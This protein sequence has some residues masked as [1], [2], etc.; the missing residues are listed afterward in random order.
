M[1]REQRLTKSS[2]FATVYRR[3]NSWGS[4]LLVMRAFPN[5]LEQSRFG[6]SVSK[7]VGKAVVRNRL[8]RLLR[9]SVRLTPLKPG[10]D[11][12]FIA[13]SAA[14]TADYHQLDRAVRKLIWQAHLLQQPQESET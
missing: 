10:W 2:Q 13:R 3:G 6:F 11:I 14:S 7:K 9:E 4:A 5:G 1:G 12:I 8:K